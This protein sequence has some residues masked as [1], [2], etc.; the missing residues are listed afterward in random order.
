VKKW[1]KFCQ[2]HILLKLKHNINRGKN[3]VAKKIVIFEKLP[4]VNYRP[5]GENLPNLVTLVFANFANKANS[6]MLHCTI[7]ESF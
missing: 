6:F 2:A 1:P 3:V 5:M 4:R 7:I